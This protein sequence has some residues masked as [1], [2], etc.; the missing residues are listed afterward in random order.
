MSCESKCCDDCSNFKYNSFPFKTIVSARR[1]SRNTHTLNTVQCSQCRNHYAVRMR[2][3][4]AKNRLVGTRHVIIDSANHLTDRLRKL[5]LSRVGFRLQ[6]WV[7]IRNCI[8]KAQENLQDCS[9]KFVSSAWMHV[10][11]VFDVFL[12][13]WHEVTELIFTSQYMVIIYLN[14]GERFEDMTGP[15]SDSINHNKLLVLMMFSRSGNSQMNCN[16][17]ILHSICRSP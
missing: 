5:R 7:T 1:V 4:N 13:L 15:A 11:L 16:D 9:E 2:Q 12:F 3:I 14:Y 8:E 17:K 6:Q 10:L